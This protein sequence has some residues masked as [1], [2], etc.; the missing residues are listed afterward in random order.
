MPITFGVIL[1]PKIRGKV[2]TN[3]QNYP[4]TLDENKYSKERTIKILLDS[5]K[6]ASIVRKD[7]F[8]K[9]LKIK[10]I[11]VPPWQGHL[12]LVL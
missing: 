9:F 12:I 5:G 10:R 4:R 3:S 1:H 2:S 11:N 6:S 7:L 8:T